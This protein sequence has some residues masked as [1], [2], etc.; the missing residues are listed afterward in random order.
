[1]ALSG[2]LREFSKTGEKIP[3]SVV[4][5]PG[6]PWHHRHRWH[7]GLAAIGLTVLFGGCTIAWRRRP[8][9]AAASGL[10]WRFQRTSV[11]RVSSDRG[12]SDSAKRWRTE[13]YPRCWGFYTGGKV[14]ACE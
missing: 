13:Q 3:E 12:I 11:R 2:S 7:I 14:Q 6:L 4:S 5:Q 10:D 9:S 8:A 1:M